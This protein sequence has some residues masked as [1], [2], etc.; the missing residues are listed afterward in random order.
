[1]LFYAWLLYFFDRYEKEPIPLLIGVFSWGAIFAAGVAFS[2]NSFS[3]YGLY[4]I[5]KSEFATQLTVSTI[6]APMVEET[7]KGLAVLLVYLVYRSDFDSP[8]DGL[9]YAGITALGFAATENIWY[10]YQLGYQQSGWQGLL[11]LFFIRS[12]V[13]GW[14]HPFYTSFIGLG[15]ALSRRAR[16]SIWKWLNPIFGL[17]IAVIFHLIHNLFAILLNSSQGRSFA[18]FWDWSGYIGLLILILILIKREQHWMKVY[19]TPELN[20]E[21]I[22]K[23]QYQIACSAYRQSLIFIR[24]RLEGNFKSVRCFY[25]AC[26]DLMHKNRQI[27]RH[28]DDLGSAVEIQRLRSKISTMSKTLKLNKRNANDLA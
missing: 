8:L 7:L 19:L 3:S 15:F 1:M 12:F 6:I 10:I 23:E 20:R 5:T 27:T 4:A 14:Q 22:T 18:I 28:G 25:Q 13:V 11:D 9:I 16:K 24:A 17:G 2:I 21:I 26:G